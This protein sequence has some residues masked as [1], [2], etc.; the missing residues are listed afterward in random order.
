ME[1]VDDGKESQ[2][3]SFLVGARSDVCVCPTIVLITSYAVCHTRTSQLFKDP[4]VVHFHTLFRP[5]WRPL[6]PAPPIHPTLPLLAL[7]SLSS[8][9]ALHARTL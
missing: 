4:F 7:P 8:P 3:H 5:M 6:P 2:P 1:S 9:S